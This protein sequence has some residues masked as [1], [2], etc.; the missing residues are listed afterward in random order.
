[1]AM[2]TV[3]SMLKNWQDAMASPKTRDK[4]VAGT[5]NPKQNPMQAAAAPDAMQRYRD[6]VDRS[7]TSGKRANALNS[8][9][10]SSYVQGC[11]TKGAQALATA[12]QRKIDNA[13]K[14]FT[15]AL[16]MLQAAQAAVQGMPKGG[17]ANAQ[18]RSN[19]ALAALMNAAGTA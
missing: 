4:Y 6:G 10:L 9:P 12:G 16:P 8:T 3:E 5:A 19:A 7:I 15:R 2:L 14:G 13:R 18:A 17:L 11:A 1:M